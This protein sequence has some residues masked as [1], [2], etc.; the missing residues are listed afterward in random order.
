MVKRSVE[1]K[2]GDKDK[3]FDQFGKQKNIGKDKMKPIRIKK[4][5]MRQ[6]PLYNKTKKTRKWKARRPEKE[7]TTTSKIFSRNK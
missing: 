7:L 6:E 1:K 5:T 4:E 3:K 2:T